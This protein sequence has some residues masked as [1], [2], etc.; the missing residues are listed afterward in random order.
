MGADAAGCMSGNGAQ[1][2]PRVYEQSIR[3]SEAAFFHER[4]ATVRRRF[5]QDGMTAFFARLRCGLPGCLGVSKSSGDIG[6]D[7]RQ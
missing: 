2:A 4:H 1:R 7:N 6:Y 3:E 5:K